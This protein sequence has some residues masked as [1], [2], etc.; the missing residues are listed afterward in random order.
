VFDVT[1]L[2]SRWNCIY[3]QGCQGVLT[4]EAP[5]LE[6]GCC[7]Y[8][9]HFTDAADAARV[10]AVAANLSGEHWQFRRQGRARGVTKINGAGETVT[11][12][13]DDA[14]IFLNRP[15]FPGGSG[16]ALHKAALAVGKRPMDFKPE[17]CWQ[18]PLRREDHVRDDGH[19]TSTITEWGRHHWGGGGGEFAWWCTE[20]PE[21]FA[22]QVPVY[23]H[24]ADELAG[25]VGDEMYRRLAA[26]LGERTAPSVA[27]PHPV[28]RRGG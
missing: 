28:V 11:R 8:G 13:V 19:V 9:A 26:Y 14:C 7:S 21:A 2:L 1:F 16:C 23:R 10:E 25:M 4:A 20:A 24:M 6:L 5:E 12:M 15:G 22:G 27:L 18:V 17:V 3:G